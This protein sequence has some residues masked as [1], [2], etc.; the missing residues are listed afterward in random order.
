MCRTLDWNQS[1]A[2]REWLTENKDEPEDDSRIFEATKKQLQRK[3]N[4]SSSEITGHLKDLYQFLHKRVE[5]K[6]DLIRPQLLLVGE[7]LSDNEWKAFRKSA[8]KRLKTLDE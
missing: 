2:I 7:K 1:E 6:E 3:K 5:E 4:K 8:E